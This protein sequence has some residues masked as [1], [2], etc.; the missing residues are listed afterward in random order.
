MCRYG[1]PET[2][3]T[4]QGSVFVGR[5]VMKFA[6]KTW[7]KFLTFTPY[8]AQA[9]GQVEAEK[10][11]IV[12]LIKKHISKKSGSLHTTLNQALW[13]CRTSPKETT[14]DMPFRL[15]FGYNAVL[16]TEICLHSIR[17][18]R[19]NE[20]PSGHFWS[21]MIDE[22]V[23]LDEERLSALD[24]LMWQNKRIVETYN[25][26]VMLKVFSATSSRQEEYN[27]GKMVTQL[28]GTL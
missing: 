5:K 11:V 27:F 3:T 8:Y 6:A 22:L 17:I 15:M 18:Q 9:N 16:P 21:M 28:G 2:I 4:E 19:E 23:D 12:N 10:K 25:R 20:I 1:T 7:I 14:N 24:A 26:K 13:A